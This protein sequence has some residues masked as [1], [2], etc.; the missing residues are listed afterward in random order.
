MIMHSSFR[1]TDRHI[2]VN[3]LYAITG[4]AVIYLHF[5]LYWSCYQEYPEYLVIGEIYGW[6]GSA[7]ALYAG[8]AAL[9]HFCTA[10]RKLIQFIVHHICNLI[11]WADKINIA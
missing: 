6:I 8:Y 10:L 11:K 5:C 2:M 3:F 4:F 1:N 9:C 7:I